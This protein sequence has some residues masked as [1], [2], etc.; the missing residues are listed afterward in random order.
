MTWV[1]ID[2]HFPDHPKLLK[3][4]DDYDAFVEA[5]GTAR[6]LFQRIVPDWRQANSEPEV[7]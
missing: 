1:K 5:G 6:L 2:D 7:A 4:G 3:L